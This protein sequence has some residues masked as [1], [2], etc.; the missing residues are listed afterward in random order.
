MRNSAKPL[1][2]PVN[3]VEIEAKAA[4]MNLTMRAI[5]RALGYKETYFADAKTAGVIAVDF[6]EKFATLTDTA[7]KDYELNHP[8]KEEKE[9]AAGLRADHGTPGKHRRRT[10]Q[11]DPDCKRAG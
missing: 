1:G 11:P 3:F 6:V 5:C 8:P 2:V 9:N 4:T 7:V 10:G